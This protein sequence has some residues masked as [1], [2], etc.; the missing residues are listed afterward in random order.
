LANE[1]DEVKRRV[2]F[3][4]LAEEELK[5]EKANAKAEHAK[6]EKKKPA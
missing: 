3:Q 2:L 6:A 4:L 5:L 1:T